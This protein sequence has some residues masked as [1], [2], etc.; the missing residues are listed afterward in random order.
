MFSFVLAT[1]TALEPILM[2][3]KTCIRVRDSRS[4]TLAV[5]ILRAELSS[6]KQAGPVRAFICTE[7]LK[8]AITSL[9]EPYFVDVQKDLA[10]LIA[11][12]I[13]LDP[14]GE[15][16]S[17]ILQLPGMAGKEARVDRNFRKIVEA[18]TEKMQRAVVLDLLKDV[19]GL[20]IQEIGRIERS[21]PKRKVREEYVTMQEDKPGITR[22]GEDELA[23]IADM[24][25]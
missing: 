24:F 16:R 18:K 20:S 4:C 14:E 25:A 5:R 8:D 19:R 3:I 6:F 9:H 22:G 13:L 11:D 10:A 21:E 2:F 1:P 12:I 15:P 7:M 17:I 23:G